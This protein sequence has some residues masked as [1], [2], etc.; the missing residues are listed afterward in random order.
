MK[1]VASAAED[2]LKKPGQLP[3]NATGA[4]GALA[5]ELDLPW[6]LCRGLAVMGRA[7]GLVGHI[8]EELRNP[9]AREIWERVEE[10]SSSRP[11]Q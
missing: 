6:R 7:V 3:V 2:L 1:D 5:C 11:P 9:L 8:A 4:L 10:E